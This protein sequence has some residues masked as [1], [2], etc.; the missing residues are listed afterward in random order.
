MQS[1]LALLQS[2]VI[3]GQISLWL[4]INL[5]WLFTGIATLV[6]TGS[7]GIPIGLTVVLGLLVVIAFRF[8]RL[9][10]PPWLPARSP[11]GRR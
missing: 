4:W 1:F 6:I 3:M 11:P 9:I 2:I 8:V 5:H 10:T 7:L